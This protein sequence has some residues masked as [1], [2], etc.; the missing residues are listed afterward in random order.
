MKAFDEFNTGQLGGLMSD[1]AKETFPRGSG[2]ERLLH[3]I[4][5]RSA[6]GIVVQNGNGNWTISPRWRACPCG[7]QRAM[8]R[9]LQRLVE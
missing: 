1:N 5:E 7:S 6:P 3:G 8:R 2:S 9:R 4:Y